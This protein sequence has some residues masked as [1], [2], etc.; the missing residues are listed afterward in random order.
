MR[1]A[2]SYGTFTKKALSF[3]TV[4]PVVSPKKLLRFEKSDI[5]AMFSVECCII[6][7]AN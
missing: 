4:L 7:A 3:P 1:T 6:F 2:L 5:I